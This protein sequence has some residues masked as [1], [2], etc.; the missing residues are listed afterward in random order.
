M[1]T[2]WNTYATSAIENIKSSVTERR[3]EFYK[4]E[5]IIGS[6]EGQNLQGMGE[7]SFGAGSKFHIEARLSVEDFQKGKWTLCHSTQ[8]AEVEP[9]NTH[10]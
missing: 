7:A 2:K 9:L 6:I 10:S 4:A 5:L 8:Q 3:T 1:L